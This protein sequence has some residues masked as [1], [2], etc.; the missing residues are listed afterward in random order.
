MQH[1]NPSRTIMNGS[2]STPPKSAAPKD[3]LG[4][5]KDTLGHE[6]AALC[7]R[8]ARL[9]HHALTGLDWPGLRF[10]DRSRLDRALAQLESDIALARAVAGAPRHRTI[11][12]RKRA[13]LRK[14]GTTKAAPSGEA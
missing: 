4:H 7:A 10:A 14:T 8:M 2:F 1:F 3:T 12:M 9:L 6:R 5:A 11:G 13:V